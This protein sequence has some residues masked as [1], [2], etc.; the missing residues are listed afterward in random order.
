MI[1]R[2]PDQ[3]GVY[4]VKRARCRG[5]MAQESQ[6]RRDSFSEHLL[7]LASACIHPAALMKSDCS[8]MTGPF[9]KPDSVQYVIIA[10][11]YPAQ[12]S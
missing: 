4:D 5:Q 6:R 9:S 12:F 7:P 8:E 3:I 1:W 10:V 11:D 2:T